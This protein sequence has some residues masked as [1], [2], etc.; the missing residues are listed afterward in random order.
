MSKRDFDDNSVRDL[1]AA[2]PDY[3]DADAF[4][5]RVTRGLWLKLWLRQ[6]FVVLAGFIGGVYA[7]VQFLHMPAWSGATSHGSGP[8]AILASDTDTTLRNGAAYM[9]QVSHLLDQPSHYLALMQTPAFFW[10]SFATCF[11]CLG[12]W[13][14]Y[15]HEEA[16]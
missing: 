6:G 4:H 12:L 3:P 11:A 9:G 13:Y 7:L 14:A 1:F 5:R 10:V 16:L 15:S 2:V 8:V